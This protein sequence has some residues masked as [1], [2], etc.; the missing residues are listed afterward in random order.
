VHGP[1]PGAGVGTIA[2]PRR[3]EWCPAWRATE[4]LSGVR[5]DAGDACV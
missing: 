1:G 2:C 3:F 4:C 5:F